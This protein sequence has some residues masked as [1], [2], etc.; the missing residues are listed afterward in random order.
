[1]G[2]TRKTF[3]PFMFHSEMTVIALFR[4]E[5]PT[6]VTRITPSWAWPQSRAKPVAGG[7]VRNKTRAP[8]RIF[9][10]EVV[11]KLIMT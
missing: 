9:P 11:V 3:D 10:F 8:T 5:R 2:N 1:M 6:R 7:Q 4:T